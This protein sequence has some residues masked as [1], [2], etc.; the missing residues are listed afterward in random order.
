MRRVTATELEM[1]DLATVL[2]V[3]GRCSRSVQ[4][5]AYLLPNWRVL[6]WSEPPYFD[7]VLRQL[8]CPSCMALISG[9]RLSL[10]DRVIPRLEYA[11]MPSNLPV[12]A[13]VIG[14]EE[15]HS[16]VVAYAD[17]RREVLTEE[18]TAQA[19]ERFKSWHRRQVES[20]E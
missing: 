17:G 18:Q 7:R 10:G 8:T 20:E 1:K 13:S 14:H 12:L 4:G 6:K 9:A 2:H 19:R 15:G 16:Y 3:C 11:P 5:P